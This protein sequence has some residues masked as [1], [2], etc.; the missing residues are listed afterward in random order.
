MS[1]RLFIIFAVVVAV[2]GGFIWND[3]QAE[4]TYVEQQRNELAA[5][6]ARAE[7]RARAEQSAGAPSA[8][9]GDQDQTAAQQQAATTAQPAQAGDEDQTAAQRQAGTTG[10]P[11]QA[12]DQDQTAGQRQ[13]GTTGQPAQAGEQDQTAGQQ[14][15]GTTGATESEDGVLASAGEAVADAASDATAGVAGMFASDELSLANFRR[16]EVLA[17]IEN[18]GHLTAEQRMN[19]RALAEGASTATAMAE[20]AIESIRST[21]DQPVSN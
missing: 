21:L 14:Q 11:A 8:R 16:D 20:A 4:R 17:R 6:A 9:A 12:G 2:V 10:Q 3:R 5:Q 19:L 7:D 1:P 18:A 13:A 15:T